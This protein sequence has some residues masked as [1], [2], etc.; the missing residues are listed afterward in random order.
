MEFTSLW[1][2]AS[3]D[4]DE[5][6]RERVAVLAS[7]ASAG[8]WQFLA[9]AKSEPEFD[10]RLAL[11]ESQISTVAA[12][13]GA[14]VEDIE[15]TM[16]RRYALL[17]EASDDSDEDDEDGDERTHGAHGALLG[18]SRHGCGEADR[19]CGRMTDVSLAVEQEKPLTRSG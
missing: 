2:E 1:D 3:R 4:L 15:A 12:E 19:G 14:E 6:S 11:A 13:T 10:T 9:A 5:E 16:R 7:Q 18:G 17:L 8:I